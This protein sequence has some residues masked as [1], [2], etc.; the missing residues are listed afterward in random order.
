MSFGGGELSAALG[1]AVA[2][3]LGCGVVASQYLTG[4]DINIALRCRLADGRSVFIKTNPSPP[5]GLFQA[6]AR[7]LE[8]LRAAG[9][10]RIPEVLAV[11]DVGAPEQFLALEYLAAGRRVG[12]FDQRCGEGLAALHQSLP[13]GTS[14][15][16]DHDNFIG[17]LPQRN[18]GGGVAASDW[19]DF[20]VS[21]R[22]EP[23]LALAQQSG[24]ASKRMRQGLSGLFSR[25]HGL[26]GEPE[27]AARLHGDLWGGNLHADE[28]GQP[29]L[30]DPAAYAGHRE[31]DLA[32]MKL[33][34]G[35]SE[36]VFES[37]HAAHPLQ[38]GH[39]QRVSLYQLYP[40]L[41]HVNLFGAGYVGA[42]ERAL[43]EV[44]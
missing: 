2:E 20:Y 22:L 15:G 23:Q 6:E 30:I 29:V 32:M 27:P 31:V 24:L 13:S 12:D 14:F 38:P 25:I 16:L 35:F 40:L 43:S 1:R 19:A 7:G 9:A 21:Q 5:T 37:Y 44:S 8:W 39:Q 17:R 3:Q 10:L 4:G 42:V 34:G 11:A 33:F 41:V 26:M 28:A 36:R 18:R